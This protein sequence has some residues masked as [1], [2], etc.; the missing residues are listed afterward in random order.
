[1][2]G[3]HNRKEQMKILIV[4]TYPDIL[5]L[6]SYNVQ[7]IGLAKALTAKGNQCDIVL[8]GGKQKDHE[9]R[10]AFER[11]GREYALTIYWLKGYSFLKNG[12]MPS[13][14]K[15]IP[16]Y[17]VIQV[18]EY[19]QL[20]S[21]WIYKKGKKPVVIYHGPY[22]HSYSRRYNFK[23]KIFDKLFLHGGFYKKIPVLTKSILAEEYLIQKGFQ[24][25]KTVGVGLDEGNFEMPVCSERLANDIQKEEVFRVLYVGKIEDRRN[26][27]FLMEVFRRL[28]QKKPDTQLTIIG[29]GEEQ[30]VKNFLASIETELETGSVK[31]LPGATQLQLVDVY[32]NTDL[33]LFTSN[34]EIFGMVLLEAMYFRVPVISSVNG[35]SVTLIEQG[36]NGYVLNEFN[37]E[38]WL[39]KTEELMR[40]KGKWTKMGYMAERTIKE[41]Y[42]WDILADRFLSA[43]QEALGL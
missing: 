24:N 3:V 33:F 8:F 1:M 10:F 40:D 14:N 36:K 11:Q 5:N 22:Y 41:K 18:N 31:Y 28:H 34:Y 6:H 16:H 4:R 19:D 23:C 12:I 26:V 35:G 20:Q 15:L 2:T 30:Y 13:V 39:E 42:L 17:D 9:E 29:S 25:V 21:Y 37:V 43:Y 27:Y 38:Q 7:E 32:K